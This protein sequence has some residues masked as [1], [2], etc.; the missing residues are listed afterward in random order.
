[1]KVINVL[2][3]CG[4]GAVTSTIVETRLKEIASSHNLEISTKRCA[5]SALAASIEGIDVVVTSYL[6]RGEP[7][8]VPILS[9]TALVTGVN[10][11]KFENEFV[12]TL[13]NFSK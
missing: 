7:L 5:A 10:E 1:M 9:G 3:A 11:A 2:V 6:Y 4:S 13:E 8:G 12:Q